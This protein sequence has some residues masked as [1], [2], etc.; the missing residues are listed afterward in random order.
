MYLRTSKE[1]RPGFSPSIRGLSSG[2]IGEPQLSRKCASVDVKRAVAQNRLYGKMLKWDAQVSKINSFLIS[3]LGLSSIVT[4]ED[5]ARAVATWQCRH[6]GDK[7]PDGV[8]GPNTWAKLQNA[9]KAA[10]SPPVSPSK[11]SP[12]PNADKDPKYLAIGIYEAEFMTL[13]AVAIG[14]GPI[15]RGHE[16]RVGQGGYRTFRWCLTEVH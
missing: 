2:Y 10:S 15:W 7:N 4:P 11:V 14:L 13:E 3:A 1:L 5:L 12:I 8:I 9:M 6:G 16:S